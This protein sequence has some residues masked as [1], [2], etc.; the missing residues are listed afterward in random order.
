[1][2][3]RKSVYILS[4]LII[5]ST[6]WSVWTMA[7]VMWICGWWSAMPGSAGFPAEMFAI[8]TACFATLGCAIILTVRGKP[9]PAAALVIVATLVETVVW[10]STMT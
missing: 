4:G 3:E 9:W 5:A 8:Y 2:T 10:L 1:M 7:Y 6:A